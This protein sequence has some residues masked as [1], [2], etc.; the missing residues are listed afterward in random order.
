[1][2][3]T[4]GVI[5]AAGE[6]KR[7]DHPNTPK[8]LV[9][10]G[11]KALLL[12]NIEQMQQAGIEKIYIVVGHRADE[13]Q[14]E[15]VG[16]PA[17]TASLEYIHQ[18]DASKE[19]MLSSVLALQSVIEGPF[20]LGMAD[21]IIGENPY[22][23]MQKQ[24]PSLSEDGI[25]SLIGTNLSYSVRSGA[26]S[27]VKMQ[28]SLITTLG[29]ELESYDGLEVG[30]YYFGDKS[31]ALLNELAD[32]LSQPRRFDE[33]LQKI[34]SYKKLQVVALEESEWFD[35]NTPAILIRANIFFRNQDLHNQQ[36]VQTT[37][38]QKL[39]HFSEFSRQ[40]N[41]KTEISVECGLLQKL[42]DLILVPSASRTSQHI[43]I[44]DSI[45]DTLYGD[46]VLSLLR[47]QGLLVHKIVIKAGESYK[48]L[49]EYGR[50]ADEIFSKKIDKRSFLF[51][52]GG[53]VINNIT[54]FL[55][56]TLYR[57]IGLIHIPTS[58][59]AQ[60]DAALDFKQ[61]VNSSYGKNLLGSYYPARSILIDPEMLQT[62]DDRHIV[63][64]ISES[65]KHA[66]AQD[67]LFFDSLLSYSGS[68]RD[69]SFLDMVVKK[70]IELK[71]PL[72]NGDVHNDYN[73]MLPQYGHC[74]G[75]AIEHL[76]SYDLLHGE[77]IAIGM[78]ISAEIAQL[79]HICD[80]TV[81][82]K[83]YN[84]FEK[85]QL[86]T[87]VPKTMEIEDIISTIRYDKHYLQGNPEMALLQNIG[88]PWQEN[89]V[90]GIPIDYDILKKGIEI[91]KK[92]GV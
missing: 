38:S 7:L 43:L 19:G 3:T 14:K 29:Q 85:F 33:V 72:L 80:Q 34:A 42:T 87:V 12:W 21:L 90:Y 77:A 69:I 9:K 1:M 13:I 8:P 27:R 92:R 89:G 68:V 58:T 5:L 64:G 74:I 63:N 44:T 73:E 53:G 22:K 82:D 76:S 25:L 86:P 55:A 23:L 65:I 60:V 81:V 54:G 51:S 24:V 16:N 39:P 32:S 78:C 2:S 10:V 30:I 88:I 28:G 35:V 66:L 56:S 47:A 91:N 59:M 84:I 4:I 62:L 31:L 37:A 83:H 61:A 57:G 79:L 18:T 49:F 48:N 67:S 36:V 20:F 17:I 40:K 71:V 41:M 11:N 45:V 46:H 75:H 50:V 70:S 15:L 52:L 6:G 26:L